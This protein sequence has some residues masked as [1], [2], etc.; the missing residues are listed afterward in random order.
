MHV[1][2][3]IIESKKMAAGGLASYSSDCRR[4]QRGARDACQA[5]SNYCIS[6]LTPQSSCQPTRAACLTRQSQFFEFCSPIAIQT[7]GIVFSFF[8]SYYLNF[9][10]LV[11]DLIVLTLGW[12]VVLCRESNCF[13]IAKVSWLSHLLSWTQQGSPGP[14]G[15]APSESKWRHHELTRIHFEVLQLSALNASPSL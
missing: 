14:P 10:F 8:F 3:R 7:F 12:T 11:L 13:V 2:L 1:C 9:L 5:I 15:A 6:H 4:L